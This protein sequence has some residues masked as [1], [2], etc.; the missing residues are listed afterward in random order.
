MKKCSYCA[1]EIQDEAIKCRY[2]GEFLNKPEVKADEITED[3]KTIEEV[4]TLQEITFKNTEVDTYYNL[5]KLINFYC[6]FC[7]HFDASGVCTQ[8]HAN[9]LQYPKKFIKKCNGQKF[10]NNG[11]LNDFLI[12]KPSKHIDSEQNVN[13]VKVDSSQTSI[14]KIIIFISLGLILFSLLFRFLFG[15]GEMVGTLFMI[16]LITFL[17]MAFKIVIKMN[18][19]LKKEPR[20]IHLSTYRD[21]TLGIIGLAIPIIATVIVSG[22]IGGMRVTIFNI[23]LPSRIL[24]TVTWLGLGVTAMILSIEASKI[25]M[26]SELDLKPNGKRYANPIQ[27]FF[28][29]IL[30][31]IVAYPWYFARRAR[32]GLKNYSGPAMFILLISIASVFYWNYEIDETKK[33][34]EN[35]IEHFEKFFE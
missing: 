25:K 24:A 18:N 3:L 22:W 1:E 4:P 8:I 27:W 9:I 17:V 13:K 35:K 23:D 2:C 28:A 32:Y 6:P 19:E 7:K 12:E 26:G 14:N 21:E 10:T 33:E 34:L 11:N 29:L 31:L 20:T 30:L 15:P 16:G 5:D